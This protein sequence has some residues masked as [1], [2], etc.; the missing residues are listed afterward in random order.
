MA[1]IIAL[2]KII[3][4]KKIKEDKILNKQGFDVFS[5]FLRVSLRGKKGMP[6]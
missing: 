3:A 5:Q 2:L 6:I 4:E 1:R